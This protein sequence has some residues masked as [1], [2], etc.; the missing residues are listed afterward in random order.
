MNIIS[1]KYHLGDEVQINGLYRLIAKKD[2]SI[3]EYLWEWINTWDGQG[4]IWLMLEKK[5][6][7]NKQ[8]IGQ[9]S[10]IPTP[11]SFWGKRYLAGKTE[12]CMSH[13]DYRGT[14]I[15]FLHEKEYFEEAKKRFQLFFTTA[16][17]AA[18]GA[19]GAVRRKLNYTAFDSWLQ[20]GYCLNSLALNKII[21]P[22]IE[23][24]LATLL[25]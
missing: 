16:G 19:P 23:K 21:Y 2:R 13:P 14:G 24:K 1:R 7:K 17:N 6:P 22:V 5:K 4:S 18:K 15:Y 11:F 25:G 10:L 12:N 20:Y 9:Y 3:Q 8:I